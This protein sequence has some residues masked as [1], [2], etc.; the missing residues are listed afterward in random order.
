[1]NNYEVGPESL[2]KFYS[3]DDLPWNT[4]KDIP[5][6]REVVGQE[7][8]VN[9]ILFGLNMNSAGYNIYV[10]GMRNTENLLT[11]RTSGE[12]VSGKTG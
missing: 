2:R 10:T 8:G 5:Q 12:K 11:N 4:T 9:S 7:R 3:L 6:T 1:M